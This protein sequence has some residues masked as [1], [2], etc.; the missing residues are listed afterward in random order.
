MTRRTPAKGVDPVSRQAPAPVP[1]EFVVV[2]IGASAG[3]L[4]PLGLL[5]DSLPDESGMAFIVVQHLDPT[6]DSLLVELLSHHT[7]MTVGEAVDGV[8]VVPN[9]VYVIPPG[10]YLSVE[11]GRLKL[12]PPPA[13][14]GGRLP[15]DHTLL[16][17]ATAYA[18]NAVAVV[19]SGNGADGSLGLAAVSDGSGLVIAQA[20]DEAAHP[21]MPQNAIATG[22]VDL[23]LPIAAMAEALVTY[24]IQMAETDAP[25]RAAAVKPPEGLAEIVELLR[26][27]TP[28]DYSLY[29]T[30]TIQRRIERRM[31]LRS[32]KAGDLAAYLHI[33]RN[34]AA[35]LLQLAKDLLIH[36]TG[37]FRDPATFAM[38]SDKVIP[39]MLKTHPAGTPVRVWSVGC[40]TGEEAYSLAMVIYEALESAGLHHKVQ[41]FASDADPD[42]IAMARDG[43]YATTIETS[44]S[45]ERLSRFFSREDGGYRVLPYLRSTIVFTV[46]NVLSDPPFSRLDLVSCRNV[47]IYLGPEAQAKALALFHFALVPAGVLMLGSSETPGSIAGRFDIVSKSQRLFRKA[48]PT[49]PRDLSFLQSPWAGMRAPD[50]AGAPDQRRGHTVFADICRQWALDSYAPAVVLLNDK[51]ECLYKLGPVQRY[52]AVPEGQST[53]D[54]LAMASGAVRPALRSALRQASRIFSGSVDGEET[55]PVRAKAS[56]PGNPVGSDGTVIEVRAARKNNQLFFLVSFLEAR[57]TGAVVDDLPGGQDIDRARAVDLELASTRTELESVLRAFERA[58]EEQMAINEEASSA[59]EEYQSANEELLTSQEEL[60]SLNEELTALNSQLQE[61]LDRQRTTASDLQN[62]LYST[63]VATLF[64][65][66]DLNIRF[67]TPMTRSI[68][69]IIATDIGRP[70]SDLHSLALD[71]ELAADA[72]SVLDHH[73][74]VDREVETSTGLWFLRRVMPYLTDSD[75]VDGVVITFTDITERNRVAAALRLAKQQADLANTAKTRFLGAASHDLRQ[76]LHRWPCFRAC[77]PTR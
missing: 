33:L 45:P 13:R 37:F 62:V 40:S 56:Y 12:T 64:L 27:R 26:T 73:L 30:G 70:L 20:P 59:S 8:P 24:S 22:R 60:Q 10:R 57:D 7:R 36:V 58:N 44:V 32:I 63:N 4:E 77:L 47:L 34:D 28:H 49:S 75:G 39:A 48:G 71:S 55:S 54:I 67:F 5:L 42:A 2:G 31:T 50:Q 46:Q 11:A 38:L 66:R 15:F 52:L 18:A 69:R 74:P 9:H 16:S 29:K 25:Q 53:S 1:L 23:C 6:H 17:L 3:G 72:A 19:L 76:P 65:D 21:A 35:E 41:V 14:R 43:F 51:N 68:F 61:T